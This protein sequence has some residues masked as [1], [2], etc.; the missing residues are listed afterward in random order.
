MDAEGTICWCVALS[1][2][3]RQACLGGSKRAGVMV[4]YNLKI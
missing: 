1:L 2:L 3:V 4:F